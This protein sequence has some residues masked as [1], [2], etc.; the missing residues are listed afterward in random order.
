M[1]SNTTYGDYL[2]PIKQGFHGIGMGLTLAGIVVLGAAVVIANFSPF[3]SFGVAAAGLGAIFFLSRRDA[4]GRSKPEVA[5]E[6]YTYRAQVRSRRNLY[7]SG[8]LSPVGG[9]ETSLPGILSRVSIIEAKDGYGYPFALL[10]HGRTGEYSLMMACSSQGAAL[11][12]DDVEDRYVAS[13]AALMEWLANQQGVTQLSATVD[14]SPD[15]GLRFRRTLKRHLV[16]DAPE[17]ASRAMAQVMAIYTS[18]GARSDVTLTVSFRFQDMKGRAVEDEDA[19]YMIALVIPELEERIA[20]SGGGKAHALTMDEVVAMARV[21]MDPASQQDVERTTQEDA[22]E[23]R[24]SGS[25][26]WEDAGPTAAEA[27][28]DWYRHDSGL[29]R[30]WEMCDPPRSAIT[31]T[32]MARLFKPLKACDR[33]RVTVIFHLLPPKDTQEFTEL[34]RKKARAR[35]GQDR[36]S[37]VDNESNVVKTDRQ[38]FEAVQGSV[39]VFFGMLVTATIEAGSDEQERLDRATRAVEGAAGAA[40]VNLRP[41]YAAQDTGFAASLP[42]GFNLSQ[43]KFNSAF[44]LG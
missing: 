42:F 27:G 29:S 38:A 32:T 14:T 35:S 31:S 19:V 34:N 4:E 6:K 12:D 9:G 25:L 11:I 22:E 1:A 30:T 13:W 26:Y 18:G 17:L 21:C 28:W 24:P 20:N 5:D 7:R 39:L 23:G 2:S 16:E 41:C 10:K 40:N 15:S 8:L 36:I 43:Y 37:T 3:I 44:G 33:K